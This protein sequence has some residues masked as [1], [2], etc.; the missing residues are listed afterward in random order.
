MRRERLKSYL[1][2]YADAKQ[3]VGKELIEEFFRM[4]KV[5]LEDA[6]RR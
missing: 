4:E 2:P 6:R 5:K 1:Q 3:T